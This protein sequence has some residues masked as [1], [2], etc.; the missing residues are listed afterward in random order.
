MII[1][2]EYMIPFIGAAAFMSRSRKKGS[3]YSVLGRGRRPV[4][5]VACRSLS[6]V[7]WIASPSHLNNS[8]GLLSSSLHCSRKKKKCCQL[9]C[10]ELRRSTLEGLMPY[11]DPYQEQWISILLSMTSISRVKNCGRKDAAWFCDYGSGRGSRDSGSMDKRGHGSTANLRAHSLGSVRLRPRATRSPWGRGT[12]PVGRPFTWPRGGHR[13]AA[14]PWRARPRV[15]VDDDPTH[16][17]RTPARAL[18]PSCVQ[19]QPRGPGILF[20][21]L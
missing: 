20:L 6:R 13:R 7:L 12:L 9:V 1:P 4:A 14:F 11:P 3:T 15:A 10:S 16:G 8:M 17:Y 2:V 21:S 19:R 18:P 5:P